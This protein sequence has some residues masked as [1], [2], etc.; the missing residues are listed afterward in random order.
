MTAEVLWTT[1]LKDVER[2]S[3]LNEQI[4]A[5][6][7]PQQRHPPT[8]YDEGMS[9]LCIARISPRAYRLLRR[10]GHVTRHKKAKVK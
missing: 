1:Y 7:K 6:A 8:L 10:S 2:N 9:L 4:Q 5:N 3:K